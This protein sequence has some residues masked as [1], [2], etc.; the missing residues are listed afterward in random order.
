MSLLRGTDKCGLNVWKYGME[1][2]SAVAGR[3]VFSQEI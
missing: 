3:N 2:R 1:V